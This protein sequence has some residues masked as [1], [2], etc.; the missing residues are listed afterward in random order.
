MRILLVEDAK[1]LAVFIKKGLAAQS[2]VVDC[3]YDGVT[4]ED[5]ASTDVYDLIIL[6]LMLPQKDGLSVCKS[7]RAKGTDTPILMLTAR[8]EMEDRVSGLNSGADDYLV[9]PFDFKELLARVQALLRR[10][11]EKLPEILKARD[12]TLDNSRRIVKRDSQE[13]NLSHREFALLEFLVRN[14]NIVLSRNQILNHCWGWESDAYSNVIDVY[15]RKLR[16]K[17][18]PGG[19]CGEII[20]TIRGSGYKIED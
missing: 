17:L 6:D 11:Q 8:G 13:I 15:I 3:A 5:Q 2:Y 18:N 10:P 16:R 7:L 12:I 9:K 20:K 19:E 4:A 1:K 14:K